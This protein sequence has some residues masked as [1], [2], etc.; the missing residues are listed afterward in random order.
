MIIKSEER[1]A[2]KCK[3]IKKADITFVLSARVEQNVLNV[4]CAR[5]I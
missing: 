2:V 3:H 1:R 4:A 5:N